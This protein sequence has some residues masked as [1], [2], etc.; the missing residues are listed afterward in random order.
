LCGIGWIGGDKQTR[1]YSA[2]NAHA[3]HATVQ[4]IVSTGPVQMATKDH[5][6]SRS[7]GHC[8]QRGEATLNRPI[9]ASARRYKTHY[10]HDGDETDLV[11]LNKAFEPIN[12]AWKLR[13]ISSQPI[14]D[15]HPVGIRSTCD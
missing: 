13:R 12:V 7:L 15:K 10:G 5:C 9:T 11:L 6:D 1:P 8:N 14:E 2:D 3:S 4:G